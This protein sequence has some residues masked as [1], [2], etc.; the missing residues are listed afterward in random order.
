MNLIQLLKYREVEMG[1]YKTF[2]FET[3]HSQLGVFEMEVTVASGLGLS[4]LAQADLDSSVRVLQSQPA[5]NFSDER[6]M[7]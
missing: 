1:D 7:V 3:L 4:S 6:E 5:R 2:L